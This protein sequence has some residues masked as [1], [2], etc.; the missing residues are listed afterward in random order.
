MANLILD[1]TNKVWKLTENVAQAG[2]IAR[3]LTTQ[4]T[5]I[6]KNIKIQINTRAAAN[7]TY[8]VGNSLGEDPVEINST[9]V[10][11]TTRYL[12]KQTLTP[13]LTFGTPGWTSGDTQTATQYTIGYVEQSSITGGQTIV[14]SVSTDKTVTIGAGYYPSARTI[15]IKGMTSGTQG[16]ATVVGSSTMD[17]PTLVHT[18]T[19]ISDTQT[20]V[21]ITPSTTAPTDK[22]YIALTAAVSNK[23][24]TQTTTINTAG[25]LSAK[26]QITTSGTVTGSRD[27]FYAPLATANISVNA[28][29]SGVIPT[30][31]NKPSTSIGSGKTQQTP[32]KVTLNSSEIATPYYYAVTLTAPATPITLTKGTLVPGY[33]GESSQIQTSTTGKTTQ[34]TSTYYISIAGNSLKHV[35]TTIN[36]S[37]STV[38]FTESSSKPT[39]GFWFQTQGSGRIGVTGSGWI[40]SG[41]ELSSTQATKYYVL[42]KATLAVTNNE[43]TVSQAGYIDESTSVTVNG[44]TL[45]TGTGSKNGYTT[46][47]DLQIPVTTDTTEG[48]LYIGAGYYGNTQIKLGD[49]IPNSDAPDATTLQVLSGF[50]VFDEA[51]H[52]LIGAIPTY[53]GEYNLS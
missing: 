23:A 32:G 31:V 46:R 35:S 22:Y 10:D 18:A 25:Y 19:T 15:T 44:G 51:G 6:D 36:A 30:M 40:Q 4:N 14:P 12:V 24:I 33:L 41:T 53:G 49:L 5:F 11:G 29:T 20:Q 34:G 38:A 26:S 39:N 50:E 21:E 17:K 27:L 45:S 13:S 3:T 8:S 37:S 47:N 43:I 48:Y 9:V 52:R 42:Q 2:T 16:K 28:S 1:T 7:P